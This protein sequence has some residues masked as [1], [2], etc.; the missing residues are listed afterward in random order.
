MRPTLCCEVVEDA[1]SEV[2]ALLKSLDYRLFDWA[3]RG[4]R[5]VE[6]ATFNTLAV[7]AEAS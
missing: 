1:A 6:R 3:S 2:T 5:E 4:E 7:P